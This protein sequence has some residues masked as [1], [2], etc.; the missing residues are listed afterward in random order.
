MIF[1]SPSPFLLWKGNTALRRNQSFFLCRSR[2]IWRAISVSHICI[3]L[4][5]HL[6]ILYLGV[7]SLRSIHIRHLLVYNCI[8]LFICAQIW[9]Y[10]RSVYLPG[11]SRSSL[12]RD[13][14]N[15]W[16]TFEINTFTFPFKSTTFL[17]FK[18]WRIVLGSSS[19]PSS[20]CA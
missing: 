14:V 9:A 2:W 4:C 13:S 5:V 12:A 16:H 7:Y 6:L 10:Q 18:I 3:H 15:G 20:P 19:S 11:S 8:A 17:I 1:K